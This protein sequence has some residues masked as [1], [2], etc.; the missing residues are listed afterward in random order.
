[1]TAR[2]HPPKVLFLC[3]GNSCRSQMAEGWARALLAGRVESFSAGVVKHGLN[4]RA[5]TAM[6]EAGVDI[7]GQTSKTLE[8][9]RGQEFD[10]VVTVCDRAAESCPVFPG[11]ARRI[12]TPFDDPPALAAGAATEEEAL[13]PYR[14]VRDEIRR[15]IEAFPALLEDEAANLTGDEKIQARQLDDVIHELGHSAIAP[16]E[17]HAIDER[18]L[19]ANPFD[20]FELW[21]DDALKAGMIQPLGMT[22]ATVDADGRPSAR[23]V[24]LRGFDPRGF[25]FYTNYDSR[26]GRELADRPRAALVFWWPPLE[27]QV[28][29]EGRVEK[30]TAEESDEYYQSRPRGSRLAA[31]VSRQSA[32]IAGR[33]ELE[34]ELKRLR[35]RHE[36]GEIPRPEFWGGFRVVPDRVEFWREGPDRL[37]DRI[38]Y[39]RTPDGEWEISRL[40]P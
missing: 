9:L 37:H 28:R 31:W 19:A 33:A 23:I 27:R 3:T 30:V 34:D 12:H 20:F 36:G 26:K 32:T 14:R 1:M 18:G 7:S 13:A 15:W 38:L 11:T 6:A 22:L 35:E 39:R 40:A 4:P 21:L 16:E 2:S 24:L 17:F 8:D 5:V 10:I 25:T 29:I